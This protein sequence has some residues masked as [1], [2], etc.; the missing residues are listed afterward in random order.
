MGFRGWGVEASGVWVFPWEGWKPPAQ[1][2]RPNQSLPTAPI[3]GSCSDVFFI[4]VRGSGQAPQGDPDAPGWDG[5]FGSYSNGFGEEAWSA[6]GGFEQMAR[7]IW[8]GVT[9]FPY[10][11]RY[12]AEDVPFL[13]RSTSVGVTLDEYTDSIWNGVNLL[14]T[15]VRDQ[16][17]ACPDQ[18]FVLAGYSQG[19]S[20]IHLALVSLSARD[21]VLGMA[22]IAD[23]AKV[24]NGSELVWRDPYVETPQMNNAGGI[25]TELFAADLLPESVAQWTVSLCHDGDI[26][27][28]PGNKLFVHG[29]TGLNEIR[30]GVRQHK[31]PAYVD[32]SRQLG[33]WMANRAVENLPR[34]P[35]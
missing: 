27:C 8:P 35:H 33:Y 14:R 24:S 12:A 21:R 4:G 2:D 20:V 26:V 7:A 1:E 6:Y 18:R 30:H 17:A 23:P 16:A 9:I 11:L 5:M 15:V 10:G 3:D 29:L 22:L 34:F 28:A 31:T 32:S 19:A 25:Y 13:P